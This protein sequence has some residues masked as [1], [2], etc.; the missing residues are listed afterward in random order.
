MVVQI[1]TSASA[2]RLAL[3]GL[4][5]ATLVVIVGLAV[6]RRPGRAEPP[7]VFGTV[8][9][10]TLV[11][12]DGRPV[13]RADLAGAPWVADFIFTRCVLSCPR[14]T[15]QMARLRTALPASTGLRLVSFSVD[16]D[17]DTPEVLRRYAEGFRITGRD[18][19]LLT[20]PRGA[21]R[22][23]CVGGFK[24]GLDE[25]PAAPEPGSAQPGGAQPGEA[26]VHSTRFVLVDR[27]GRIRGYYE[28]FQSESF[29]RLERDARTL[30]AEPATGTGAT[31]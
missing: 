11:E 29:A 1:R 6:L 19:L 31:S 2:S 14:M 24:L 27:A 28:G 10:F 9:D 7:P 20:G 8:P 17:F 18:W 3:W 15:A 22:E 13:T 23:L 25:A 16:P 30:L 12:R 5:G 4:L 26:I 21:I